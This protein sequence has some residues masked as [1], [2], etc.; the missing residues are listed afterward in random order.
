MNS[1]QTKFSVT[2]RITLWRYRKLLRK[3]NEKKK[4]LELLLGLEQRALDVGIHPRTT[5]DKLNDVNK[6]I[7]GAEQEMNSIGRN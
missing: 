7:Q 4:D 2:E 1:T 3:L 5:Q 6:L